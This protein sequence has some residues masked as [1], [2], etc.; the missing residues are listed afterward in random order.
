MI[1]AES[2]TF[3]SVNIDKARLRGVT[4]TGEYTWGDTTLGASAD[5]LDPE[6]VNTGKQLNRRARQVY[7]LNAQHRLGD[8]QLGAEYMFVGKRYDDIANQVRLGGYSL[9]NLTAEYAFT[10]SA[11]VQVRWDNILDKRY[12]NAYGYNMPGSTVFVNLALR[13]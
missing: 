5:F 4:L 3:R 11:S 6:D 8:L 1:G 13:M 10:R 2:I 9:M 12:S 7:R